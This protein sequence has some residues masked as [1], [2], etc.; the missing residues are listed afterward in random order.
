MEYLLKPLEWVVKLC[1]LVSPWF[2]LTMFLFALFF[3]ILLFPLD[4]KR[5]KSQ[6]KTYRIQPKLDEIKKKYANN[7]DKMSEEMQKLQTEEGYSPFG[8][9]LTSLIPLP[10]FL[11]LYSVITKP[12]TYLINIPKSIITAATEALSMASTNRQT[13]L[14]LYRAIQNGD[15]ALS[16]TEIMGYADKVAELDMTFLGLDLTMGVNTEGAGAI[17]WIFPVITVLA[18]VMSA[19][20]MGRI[21]KRNS[22]GADGANVASNPLMVFGM[23]IL[24]GVLTYSFPAGVLL[25]WIY[26][27]LLS[28]VSNLVLNKFWPVKKLAEQYD[29]EIER[30]KAEGKYEAKRSKYQKKMTEA[31]RKN[32][33]AVARYNEYK[34]MSNKKKKELERRLIAQARERELQNALEESDNV[35][36]EVREKLIKKN[37]KEEKRSEVSRIDPAK[38]EQEPAAESSNYVNYD[39]RRE[40]LKMQAK[41]N[42]KN[43]K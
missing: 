27:N 35:N 10:I 15:S 43:K 26:N 41:K 6:A 22:A 23:P 28:L 14:M 2:F 32:E 29:A 36:W 20:I 31:Q 25:Y 16:G 38:T 1:G 13:E 39:A 12:L 24:T 40:F 42:K 9:C 37:Q 4:I 5:Q 30:L 18:S 21:T 34:E 11:G 19:F 7:R 8:G 33:E 17:Y 3:K